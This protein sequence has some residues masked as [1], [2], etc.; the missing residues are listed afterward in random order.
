[1][2][3]LSIGG[4]DPSSGAGIQS[5][6]KTFDSLNAYGL[7]VITAITGQNTSSFGMIQPA[8]Q[9]IVKNQI[10]SIISDFKI[11]GIKIGMVYNS[12]IIKT[13]YKELKN[14]KIPIVVD[15]VIKSTTGGLLIERNAIKDFKKFLIP[16]ST[17]ITPNKFEAEF[18]SE[19]KI[20]SKKSLQRA[21]KKI[22]GMGAKNVI[23]TGL[24]TNDQIT[25]YI[26]EQKNQYTIS[27]KKILKTNHGSG[28][29]Y[30]ATL[31]FSLAN[32]I[33]LKEAVK[34][35]K[36]FTFNSIK[37]AKK[38]GHGI[39]ITQIK[40]KDDIREELTHA[41]NE[42]VQI[43]N[44]YKFIPECQ[45]NFVFSKKSPRSIKEILGVSGRIVKTG[46]SV[47]VA[48]DLEYGGSKHVATALI[49]MNKK[50]P[51]ICSAINLR[52]SEDIILKLR[53]K[54]VI[55][56]SYDRNDEPKTI[57]N[58]DRSSVGWGIKHAIRNLKNPPD[59]IYHKGDF[60]KEPMIIVFAKTPTSVIEK[61]S[62][63][64]I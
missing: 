19:I 37:N 63:L 49:V 12:E 30:S 14:K 50:F 59:I 48:G 23:I 16:L 55:I 25:D 8:S 35:S 2:N 17:V 51:E 52:Y 27:G 38:I 6:V 28:C 64:F 9:K 57:K 46:N 56:S 44:I 32:G 61:I 45:T 47:T 40:N 3:L 41:I 42:F 43:K 1:M 39:L 5:D 36:Q 29:N 60:G 22:Q 31:L 18:L 62:N 33:H 26:L 58:K 53:K 13:I 24:E 7:T 20:D 10:D 54:R 4:S 21:A 34:F 15:P 11:D